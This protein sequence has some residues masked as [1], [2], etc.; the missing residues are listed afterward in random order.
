MLLFCGTHT[1]VGEPPRGSEIAS[2]LIGNVT[3]GTIRNVFVM[4]QYFCMMGTFNKTSA[5]TG[6]DATMMRVPHP[7]IG[8][9]WIL[10]LTFIRPVVVLWQD[11]FSG[12]KAALR[13]RD[14]LFFGPYRP[15]TSPELSRNLSH[16]I[17]R[18]LNV[19]I[20][21]SLWRHIVTWFLNYHSVRFPEHHRLLNPSGLASQSGHSEDVHALYAADVRLPAGIGFHKFFETMRTSGIWHS[22]LEFSHF[23]K[24][25]LLEDMT[26]MPPYIDDG[27]LPRISPSAGSYSSLLSTPDIAEEVKRR[28]L[29][30]LLQTISQSRA[31]DLACIL[32]GMGLNPQSP[33]SQALRQPVTHMMHPSRLRDL[34]TFL[35]CDTASFKDPQQ[36]LAL[37][38]IR[39]KEP[40]LLVIGPTG[41][42]CFTFYLSSSNRIHLQDQ[43]KLSQFS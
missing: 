20:S 35:K 19:K 7:E 14:R 41:M 24:R 3:G 2:H 15:V 33:P 31:N 1:S 39:G 18:L 25:S 10:Y 11:H 4:F 9:L 42:H 43:G 34:R 13:A 17:Q 32:S 28:I 5:L 27:A 21:I 37:E 26:R 29:P 16:H 12:R 38:L 23:S 36:A 8:R 30:D 22:L 6:R 40:S